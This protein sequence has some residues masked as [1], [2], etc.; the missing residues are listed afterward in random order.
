MIR[1]LNVISGLNNAG[2]EAVV[3]NYYRNMDRDKIQF[4][5]LVLDTGKGYYEEEIR[6]LGGRIY[7]IPAFSQ[8]PLK[9]IRLRKKFFREHKYDIVE[10]HSPSALRFAYCKLARKRGAKAVIFHVHNS[11]AG[12]NFLVRYARKQLD[13]YCS[14][15]VT[16]S[17][18]AARCTLGKS[19]DKV[20]PNAIDYKKFA[21]CE[22]FRREVRSFYN[23]SDDEILI[24]N[25]GR[26]SAQK[27]QSFLLKAFA[28]ATLINP[29]IK[30]LLDGFGELE[31]QLLAEIS[32]LGLKDKV[33]VVE[34]G[35]FPAS[36]IYSGLDL[37][38]MPSLYE[39]LG[40]VLVEAQANGLKIIGSTNLPPESD[41]TD[42]IE[43]V[44]LNKDEWAKRLADGGNYMRKSTSQEEFAVTGYDIKTAAA[45]RQEE[46]FR[47]VEKWSR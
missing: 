40:V 42:S 20:I 32:E 12:E 1:V 9:N 45:K 3:M 18:F 14:Q 13:K 34:Q 44:G 30:L 2:T 19:A 25:I 17:D 37:F 16:C 6:S 36:K 10:V 38:A 39:G 15:T 22:E 11:I 26:F 27:N 35:V 33:I 47:M 46:Y 5:F 29:K 28:E 7:K 24:G 4:D 21:F 8:A 43:F 23:V 41:I 31:S